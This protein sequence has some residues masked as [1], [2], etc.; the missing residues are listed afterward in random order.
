M[1]PEDIQKAAEE[2]CAGDKDIER[3][4]IKNLDNLLKARTNIFQ[5]SKVPTGYIFKSG[6]LVYSTRSR[7]FGFILGPLDPW[8]D[9]PEDITA[10]KY[11]RYLMVALNK[12]HPEFKDV[13]QAIESLPDDEYNLVASSKSTG[14]F[15]IRYPRQCDL[16]LFV[17][18]EKEPILGEPSEDISNFC[19][20]QCIAECSKDCFLYKYGKSPTA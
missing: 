19:K 1:I 12:D 15:T 9:R 7:D 8:S 4:F 18:E 5:H 11:K 2:L 6:D 13:H 17:P 16:K 10:S 14:Y 20:E 3:K